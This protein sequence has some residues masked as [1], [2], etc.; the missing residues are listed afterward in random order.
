MAARTRTKPAKADRA[1]VKPV[2]RR[3]SGQSAWSTLHDLI[4]R[5]ETIGV[6]LII[7]A[8]LAVPWLV[9]F[10]SGLADARNRFV[11]TFGLMIFA[12]IGLLAYAGWLVIRDEQ[13]KLWADWRPWAIGGLAFLSLSGFLGFF[14]PDLFMGDVP[15]NE[16][17]LGGE[18][19]MRFAGNPLGILA[20]L[21]ICVAT[22]V[23][24]FPAATQTVVS[25]TP[26]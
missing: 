24:A 17:S 1:P 16:Y 15:A 21:L 22:L 19:G 7:L 12:W 8:L 18:L 23:L 2:G 14:K 20:W 11:E 25:N 9:P 10:T 4:I 5:R 6:I 13:E 26:Y 3:R